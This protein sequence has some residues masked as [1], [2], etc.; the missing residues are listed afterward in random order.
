MPLSRSSSAANVPVPLNPLRHREIFSALSDN[1][2]P[3]NPDTVFSKQSYFDSH[4]ATSIDE[5]DVPRQPMKW[6]RFVVPKPPIP[7]QPGEGFL[8]SYCLHEILVGEDVTST[9]DWADHVFMD[10]EPYMCTWDNCARADKTFPSRE[11]WFQH[12]LDNHRI[13]KVWFC[14][15]CR[16]EF[17]RSEEFEAH[18]KSIH[19]STLKQDQLLLMASM[20]ERY[21]QK[22]LTEQPC[23]LCGMHC[24]DAEVL[25]DHIGVHMEQLALTSISSDDGFDEDDSSSTQPTSY[26]HSTA[27]EL[28]KERLDEFLLDV[29]QLVFANASNGTEVPRNISTDSDPGFLGDSDDED[30]PKPAIQALEQ[31]AAVPERARRP[32]MRRNGESY[33]QKVENFLDQQA[34]VDLQTIAS[35][36][37]TPVEEFIQNPFSF[38]NMQQVLKQTEVPRTIRTMPP[39]RNDVFVGRESDLAKLYKELSIAGHTCILCG[40]AGL[41]K[42]ATAIEYTYQFEQAYSYIFWVQAETPVGCADSYGLIASQVVLNQGD[43]VQDQ[44]RLVMLSREFLEKS[45]KRWLLVFD[46]VDDLADVQQYLPSNLLDTNGSILVTTRKMEGWTLTVPSNYARIQLEVLTL[47]DSRRL[48]LS[49]RNVDYKD[50]AT[51]PEYQLA[52]EIA[53]YAERLPLALSHIA[54]YIQVSGCS[55]KDFVE[56]WKERHKHTSLHPAS[57]TAMSKTDKALE[58]VWNIGLREVTIDARELLNILAFLDSDT[59]QKDLLVGEHSEPALEILHSSEAFRQV[60]C[61]LRKVIPNVH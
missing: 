47:E 54:G 22:P 44:D 30:A 57:K 20:C 7:L 60:S 5:L 38:E 14:Q 10:L 24:S 18:L 12:E 8:C 1:G 56:L 2:M 28:K 26:E 55:L 16:L 39:P 46:N 15:S 52:G 3:S 50:M 4:S 40:S 35:T 61:A 43:G 33:F 23:A 25:K 48:L 49:S 6:T 27:M 29:R 17:A 45:D 41:G 31:L 32:A 53:N 59:I 42:S 19:D 11:A 21:S 51:H 13:P 34:H 9:E 37:A 36:L 58:I